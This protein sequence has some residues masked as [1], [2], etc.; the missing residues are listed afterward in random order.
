MSY[1]E[2]YESKLKSGEQYQDFVHELFIQYLRIEL[3]FYTTK[4]DQYKIGENEQG[5]EIKFDD[6]LKETGNLY[7]EY[8][9]KSHPSKTEYFPSGIS[10]DDN[11]WLYVIG[12]YEDVFIFGKR[13][14][15]GVKDAFK[16]VV[17]PTSKGYLIP[18]KE[19]LKLCLKHLC[20]ERKLS[21][22]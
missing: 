16:H 17:T 12:N 5:I 2:Y 20:P 14:L 7:I 1:S 3:T 19:A 21:S 8:A 6:R 15:Y 9:E 22:G 10:R 11:S 13:Q 18:K 4:L